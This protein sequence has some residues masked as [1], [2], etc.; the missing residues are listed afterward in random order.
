MECTD[1]LPDMKRSE[2]DR[3][4]KDL[5]LKSEL[6]TDCG[7]DADRSEED[8]YMEMPESSS[9]VEQTITTSTTDSS[10]IVTCT[11]SIALA[12][13]KGMVVVLF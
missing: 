11:V 6:L 7:P 13:F 3:F 10:Y 4:L 8:P 5:F 1:S 12:I 9:V 2:E